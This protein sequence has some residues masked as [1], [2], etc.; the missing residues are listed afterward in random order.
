MGKGQVSRKRA[1]AEQYDSDDGFVEDAP[2]SK[3]SKS[4]SAKASGNLEMQKDS[5]GNP[6]WEVGILTVLL[7]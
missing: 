3:K 1:A 5:D 4:G 6:Y 2:K 7:S